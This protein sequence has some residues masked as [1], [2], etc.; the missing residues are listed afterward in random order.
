MSR[1]GKKP[2]EIPSNVKVNYTNGVLSVEGPKGKLSSGHPPRHKGE[3]R[4]QSYKVGKALRCTLSQGN[5]WHH[6]CTHKEYD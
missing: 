1:I 4:K 6:G 5:S 3:H 2:I